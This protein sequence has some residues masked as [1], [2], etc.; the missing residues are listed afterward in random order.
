V[1]GQLQASATLLPEKGS[2]VPIGPTTGLVDVKKP[3][4]RSYQNLNS[5]PSAVQAVASC[6]TDSAITVPGEEGHCPFNIGTIIN[7]KKEFSQIVPHVLSALPLSVSVLFIPI[8]WIT[9]CTRYSGIRRRAPARMVLEWWNW[10]CL[11][12]ALVP[13]AVRILSATRL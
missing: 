1:N 13:S 10:R 9:P 7:P 3:K 11:L 4:P 8:G 6:Y 12:T 2:Q 5:N